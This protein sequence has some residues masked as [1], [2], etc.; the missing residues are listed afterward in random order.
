MRTTYH[1]LIISLLLVQSMLFAETGIIHA[2][3]YT[4]RNFNIDNGL[5]H[6]SVRDIAR[7]RSGFLWLSTFDGLSRYD[8]YEFRN[9]HH[10]PGDST[11]LPYFSVGK[12][13]LDR[14]DDLWIL[15]DNGK[16]ARFNKPA[17]TFS[18]IRSINGEKIGSYASV[19][20]DQKGNVW[21]FYDTVFWRY[22]PSDGVY[23]R[24][25][26]IFNENQ[27]AVIK[28]YVYDLSFENDSVFWISGN[29]MTRYIL[30]D[31]KKTVTS[32][33][34]YPVMTT[35]MPH[36][37]IVRNYEHTEW[38]K[39]RFDRKF[40]IW[41][42]SNIGLF[43]FDKGNGVF[44]EFRGRIPL[45]D[46]DRNKMICWGNIDG[47]L[48]IIKPDQ[49]SVIRIPESTVQF[50]KFVCPEGDNMLWFSNTSFTGYSLG[51][52]QLIF[53]PGYFRK[54]SDPSPDGE[55]PAIFSV[56]VDK[57]KNLWLG[58]RGR[59]YITVID[60]SGKKTRKYTP[61]AESPGI[62][63]PVRSIKRTPAGLWVGYF[64]DMLLFYDYQS[65]KFT[66][67][68]PGKYL[69]RALEA[70]GDNKLYIGNDKLEIY[71]L[72]S[73]R[74]EV[75]FDSI[76]GGGNFR[77][78]LDKDSSLWSGNPFGVVLHYTPADKTVKKFQTSNFENNIEDVC[79]ADSNIIWLASLGGGLIRYNTL[80]RTSRVYTTTEGLSNNTVYCILQDKQGYI[81]A[82]TDDGISRLNPK[83]GIFKNF[84]ISEG[85]D[86]K[87]FNSGASFI[88]DEGRFWFGG[89]GGAISFFPDSLDHIRNDARDEKIII[90]GLSTS[91]KTKIMRSNDSINLARGQDN[92][93]I[94]FAIS[95]FSM[96]DKT[97]YRYRLNG[98]DREW[99]STDHH[100]RN[101]NY[102]NLVPGI[103]RLE[104]ESTNR[105]G[106]WSVHKTVIV[107]LKPFLYQTLFF[108]I[109]I[110]CFIFSIIIA[111]VVLYLRQFNEKAKQAQ[112]ELRLQA[113]R[114]QMNPHFIFNSLNSI[115]YFISNNDKLS[116]NR[117]IADF[118]RIIRSI[119]S[120]M[121]SD[122]V[123]LNDELISVR[124]YM[125]IEHLR[126]GD[127]FDY[128]IDHTAIPDSEAYEVFPGLIQPFTENAIWH[129]IRSL[130]DRKGMIRITLASSVNGAVKC[131]I[132]DD[133][134]GRTKAN[135]I[136][137]VIKNHGSRGIAIVK[138]R[139]E[140]F[141][142]LKGQEY[143][144]EI[145]D[146]FPGKADS[147][148][149]VEIDIPCRTKS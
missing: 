128:R 48:F 8:G 138:E 121:G 15:T 134:I 88:D 39:I 103:Y 69:Y 36:G 90:T 37:K 79:P 95:D 120:N 87:E 28:G 65:G 100:N 19:C 97:L 114:G 60:P 26:G 24:F 29:P 2:Q 80:E 44:S 91:G 16:I 6:N 22:T 76:P 89:M 55:V 81:W 105:D 130:E 99:I 70:R 101:I 20:S 13:I 47:G 56:C 132:E 124:D 57:F 41:L 131:I 54:Y 1:S 63:G 96:S 5:P 83:T 147:G 32:A 126:F 122:F 82:S 35:P 12:I 107:R 17:N 9:Y 14:N 86:I 4:I 58:I 149:R 51:L 49:D 110:I 64:L 23:T 92:F 42:F 53:T 7:D 71:D 45:N 25:R 84:G 118:S 104:I 33:G 125:E 75:L 93:H 38:H 115:N 72:A 143:K 68:N 108:R 98:H 46:F 77:F 52:S 136:S 34:L 31:A 117:Y 142:K 141:S 43:C 112:D 62:Y 30:N 111:I 85:L 102:D 148:T 10:V 123:G 73:G 144:I 127:R 67:Y 66:R 129:G 146:A 78:H 140:I 11:S 59:E 135:M 137:K 94:S 40:N 139:L 61:A 113:L 18:T 133:G 106:E 3:N 119:L 21:I 50:L 145:S 109:F 116:A 74:I 27:R